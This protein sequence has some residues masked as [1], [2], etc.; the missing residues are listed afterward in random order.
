MA[1]DSNFRRLMNTKQDS[2]ESSEISSLHGMSDGQISI[3]KNDTPTPPKEDNIPVE[4]LPIAVFNES[5][6]QLS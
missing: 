6:I 2:I 5:I 1:K 4:G 3:S